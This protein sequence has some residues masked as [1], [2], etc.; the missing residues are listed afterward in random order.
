[1]VLKTLKILEAN[2][3]AATIAPTNV[4]NGATLVIDYSQKRVDDVLRWKWNGQYD[5]SKV[6]GEIKVSSA[7]ASITVAIPSEI[8]AMGLR[9]DGNGITVSCELI[10]GQTRYAFDDLKL[11]LLPLASLPT[12][13][14]SGF[15]SATVL[16]VSQLTATTVIEIEPWEFMFIG[17][18]VWMTCTRTRADGASYA[19]TILIAYKVT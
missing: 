2:A 5:V 6:E 11:V 9:P 12:V 10:R 7:A 3:S 19:N 4:L 8:V 1:V 18:P 16:P 17:Q 14:I 13:R 15:G